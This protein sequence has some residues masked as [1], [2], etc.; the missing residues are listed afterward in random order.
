MRLSDMKAYILD[1]Y[2]IFTNYVDLLS[3][4]HDV[5]HSTCTKSS[6]GNYTFTISVGEVF[7]DQMLFVNEEGVCIPITYEQEDE[8]YYSATSST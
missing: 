5:L 7:W 8:L 1:N 2:Y 3:H 4:I 6:R